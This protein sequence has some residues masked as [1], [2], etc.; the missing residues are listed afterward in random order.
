MPRLNDEWI[1]SRHG[2]VEQ[3]TDGVF[4][5]QGT[6]KMPLGEFPRRMT[7]VGL[8]GRRTAIWSAISLGQEAMEQVEALGRPRYLVVPNAYHRLDLRA[9]KK[10]YPDALVIAPDAVRSEVAEACPVDANGTALKDPQAELRLVQGTGGAEFALH[11]TREDGVTLIVNDVIARV[12]RP[13]GIT[14]KIMARLMGFGVRKPQTPRLIQKV[15]VKDRQLLANQF[16]EWSRDRSI[17]RIIPSH[18]EIIS[19]PAKVLADLA[20]SLA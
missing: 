11:V 4:T 9:W 17:K 12:A 20:R 5:V 14:A 7:I 3:V 19:R 6:I 13:K 8:R 2:P 10:R 1:V 18:G 15:L 16:L